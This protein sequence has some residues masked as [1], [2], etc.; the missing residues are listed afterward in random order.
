MQLSVKTIDVLKNFSAI[1]Q[2]LIFP[3]G[4]TIKT[5]SPKRNI[6]AIA[7]I[8]EKIPERFAIYELNQF[9]GV[10]SLFSEPDIDIKQHHVQISNGSGHVSNYFFAE[11]SMIEAPPDKNLEID[12]P[13]VSFELKDSQ[14]KQ[15]MQ[16]ARVMQ[17]TTV[18]VES[19]GTD[20]LLKAVNT[21]NAASNTYH[22]K[23]AKASDK[24][25]F[26]FSVD[27]LRLLPLT[28]SVTIAKTGIS[29]F[30]SADGMVEY[31][32]ATEHESK[33]DG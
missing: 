26:I 4:S 10:L 23:V 7:N 32:I 20:V 12:E 25:R 27:N 18:V 21:E 22:V 28:Y 11:E 30:K 14:L 3:Q 19:D 9:L 6:L 31:W 8:E 15:V 17:L 16:A 29:N 1:N 2:S 24:F 5:L 13:A 33:Y